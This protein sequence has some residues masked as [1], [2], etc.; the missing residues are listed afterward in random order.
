MTKRLLGAVLTACL[1]GSV[2]AFPTVQAASTELE[3]SDVMIPSDAAGIQ[4]FV[5][6]KHPR[7]MQEFSAEKNAAL[8]PRRD[9]SVGNCIRLADSGRVDDGSHRQPRL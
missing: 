1:A 5:R 7:G 3:S 2:I 9:I 4:L 8:C 6:N